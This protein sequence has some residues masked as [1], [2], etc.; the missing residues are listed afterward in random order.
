MARGVGHANVGRKLL[1][2][3]NREAAGEVHP[4]ILCHSL[5]ISS[6]KGRFALAQIV[7]AA[8]DLTDVIIHDQENGNGLLRP[9][10]EGQ[11][12][13][14]T[15]PVGFGLAAGIELGGGILAVYDELSVAG[16]IAH[17]IVLGLNAGSADK[18]NGADVVA[19]VVQGDR[20]GT[21]LFALRVLAAYPVDALENCFNLVSVDVLDGSDKRKTPAVKGLVDLDHDL[22]GTAFAVIG[23][24]AV[25]RRVRFVFR[26]AEAFDRRDFVGEADD[27]GLYR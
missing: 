13:E 3:G 17:E 22:G 9:A 1:V 10:A 24:S 20:A 26:E 14:Q 11:Q 8:Q 25:G 5:Q 21:D 23:R 16:I 19:A 12:R 6:G 15:A 27:E 2:G 4:L 18:P 7:A